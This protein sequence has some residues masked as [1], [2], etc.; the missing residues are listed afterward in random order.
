MASIFQWKNPRHTQ[1][2]GYYLRGIYLLI[3]SHHCNCLLEKI[4]I[5][6]HP[7]K[8]VTIF[9]YCGRRNVY[10]KINRFLLM[11][12]KDKKKD[13]FKKKKKGYRMK[14]YKCL[15]STRGSAY[16]N[17]RRQIGFQIQLKLNLPHRHLLASKKV[18][19]V[20]ST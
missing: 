5:T 13:S 12:A 4:N 7:R 17:G 9:F 8:L 19:Q 1:V 6:H 14:Q 20:N 15:K 11:P 2:D 3:A 18:G 16:Q 10:L